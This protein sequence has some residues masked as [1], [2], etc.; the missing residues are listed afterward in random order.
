L[1]CTISSEPLEHDA[2]N[3]YPKRKRIMS[4]T[5][6]STDGS[7]V[8][9]LD[10]TDLEPI[11]TL[12]RGSFGK[13]V[14]ARTSQPFSTKGE[15][16]VAVKIISRSRIRCE[17]QQRRTEAELR[18]LT[19]VA[20]SS[21]F[22]M[23]CNSAYQTDDLLV[24]VMDFAAGGDLRAFLNDTGPLSRSRTTRLAAQIVDGL[25][26][27]H[28]FG[29][30]YRDLKPDNLLLLDKN[31]IQLADFGLSKFLEP[32]RPSALGF[33]GC[34]LL[35]RKRSSVGWEK[36]L[37]ACGTPVYQCPEMVRHEAYSTEADW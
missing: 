23:S 29:V 17:A 22:V 21:R 20:Q 24:Y 4:E 13:V 15:C 11:L 31:H 28:R 33:G 18:V 5:S 36:T 32:S 25:S 7:S 19:E 8:R 26:H 37:T 1:T 9:R 12:G 14:L 35:G 2:V 16:L 34:A 6:V 3:N 10:P 27:L 30:V